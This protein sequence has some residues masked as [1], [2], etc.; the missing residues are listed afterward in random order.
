MNFPEIKKHLRV[1]RQFVKI[2]IMQQLEYRVDFFVMFITECVY[3]LSKLLY[4]LIAY[5]VGGDINGLSTDHL[6]L[7][8]GTFLILTAVYTC[9][10]MY[11]FFNISEKIIKG[12]F[13][14]MIVKPIS[15]QFYATMHRL[16]VVHP[17]PNII[18]GI[19]LVIMGWG[20]LGIS[21]SIT[22]IVSYIGFLLC[23]IVLT[24][25]LLLLPQILS[26]WIIKSNAL[27]EFV[28]RLWDFNNMPM[29]IY[30]KWMQRIGTFVIPIFVITNFPVMTVLN[31]LSLFYRIWGIVITVLLFIL[32]RLL[33]NTAIKRY[34]SAGG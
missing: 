26:F 30:N 6:L 20:R 29:L 14:M 2:C 24:Y 23:G 9:F 1:Y 15:L 7:F 8:I 13:D 27:N 16:S 18:V 10:F 21:T 17:I 34:S 25:A 22:Y 4:I 32:V 12:E 31:D 33:W 28:S 11:N 19:T 5:R 3:L